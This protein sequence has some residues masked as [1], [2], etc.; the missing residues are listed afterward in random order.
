[1]IITM[2]SNAT[3]SDGAMRIRTRMRTESNSLKDAWIALRRCWISGLPFC[4]C[5]GGRRSTVLAADNLCTGWS[6]KLA[7][8]TR[9]LR[10]EF[11]D[12]DA[13]IRSGLGG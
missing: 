8:L 11:E 4:R 1:M 6:K 12:R 10:F 3:R 9:D 13:T 5:F 7:Q 2:H